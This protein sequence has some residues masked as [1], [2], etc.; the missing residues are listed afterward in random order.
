MEPLITPAEA[1]ALILAHLLDLS[2]E[3]VPLDRAQGRILARELVADR[4][5][6][7][8]HRVM[9][10]GI[11]FRS[12]EA[13]TSPVPKI[14]GVHAAG[15]PEPA[16]LPAN[17]CW[18]VMTGAC[19]PPDCDTVVPYEETR[20][21]EPGRISFSAGVVQPGK[22]IHRA[23]S[24]FALGD[25][26]VPP[27]RRIDSRIAAVAATVGATTLPVL[28][29]PR[30][31]LFTTGDEVVPPEESP[32]PHQVR[33]SNAASLQAALPALGA[34]IVHYQHLQDD[35]SVTTDAVRNHLDCDA[36]LLCGG[37]SKGKRDYVRPVI[38]SL[39]GAPGFHGIA[40]RPGKPPAFWPGSPAVFALPGNPMSAQ[41]CFHRY[42][43]PYLEASLKQTTVLRT[44]RLAVPFRFEAPFAHFLPVRLAQ[45]EASLCAHPLPLA[46]SGD[47]ASAI[48]SDGFLELPADVADFP[49]GFLAP[50]REWL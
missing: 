9:M 34:D 22:F 21:A 7:P 31:V 14:A 30:V 18:E 28:R 13:G 8:Y 23:G 40:Q 29:K 12:A 49:E 50:F 44:T 24:D 11:C 6:P 26:L 41:I 46:N 2:V 25:I 16:A 43:R 35:E 38:E 33:Q 27:H 47:F 19:L 32:A 20:R 4:P 15:D 45:E 39:H 10:D 42:V 3:E 37:I 48:D 36:I 5:L 1:E 17:H